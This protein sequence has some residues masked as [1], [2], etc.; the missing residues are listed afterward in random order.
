MIRVWIADAEGARPGTLE[1]AHRAVRDHG[2]NVWI[3][4]EGDDEAVVREALAPF[5]VHPLVV[6]DLVMQVNR[7][8]LDNYNEYAYVV[9]HSARW[10]VTYHDAA[11]RSVESA[12]QILPKR[13]AL[14]AKGPSYLMHY[15]LDV[16]VDHYLPLVDRLAEDVDQLEEDVFTD[17]STFVSGK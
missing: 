14:L 16:L 2:G 7:P 8:K 13:P 15:V 12:T 10:I 4:F 17:T 1:E 9:V 3:D 5:G 6:E 11:T